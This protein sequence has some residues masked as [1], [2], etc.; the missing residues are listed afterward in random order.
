MSEPPSEDDTRRIP[1]GHVLLNDR[2][3]T[4]DELEVTPLRRPSRRPWFL[5]AVGVLLGLVL[6]ATVVRWI[7]APDDPLPV[8]QQRFLAAVAHGAERVREGNE[9]TVVEARRERR[10]AIC[11]LLGD[12]PV[13]DWEG[14]LTDIDTTLGGEDGMITVKVGED[15]ELRTS[16]PLLAAEDERSVIRPGTSAFSEIA[17][18]QDGDRVRFSGRFLAGEDGCFQ[19][20]SLRAR[21]GMLTPGF[22]FRFTAVEPR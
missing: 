15:A 12:R 13:R 17:D 22:V 1:A 10:R 8:Q 11:T 18:L 7:S 3:V 19:E 2:L 9:V 16:N 20:T 5:G 6:V 14:T 21:N 4:R